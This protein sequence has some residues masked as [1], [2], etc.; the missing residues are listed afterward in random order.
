[1]A[2]KEI[3]SLVSVEFEEVY[4]TLNKHIAL[5]SVF[6]FNKACLLLLRKQRTL[7]EGERQ[8]PMNRRTG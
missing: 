3:T 4:I 5:E 1:M 6:I 7:I 2:S 8:C